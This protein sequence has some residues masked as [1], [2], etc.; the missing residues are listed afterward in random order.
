[1]KTYFTLLL[2]LCL[3]TLSVFAQVDT[4]C[5]L[6]PI[7]DGRVFYSEVIHIENASANDLYS[8]SKIWVAETFHD[9]KNV[10][11]T[12]VENSLVKLKGLIPVTDDVNLKLRVR[13]TIQFKEGRCKYEISNIYFVINAID[14]DNPIEKVPA[15]T[16]CR[17]EI[18]EKFDDSTMNLIFNFKEKLSA[19]DYSW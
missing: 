1:M 19:A 8:T 11:Q 15:F 3:Y 12:D 9:A 17:I 6:L 13:M 4:V 2:G 7:K 14:I 10:I 18:L 16:E 5:N